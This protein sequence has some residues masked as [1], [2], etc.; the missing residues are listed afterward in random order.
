MTGITFDTSQVGL[1]S[2]LR[3]WQLR[4]LQVLWSCPEGAKSVTVWERVNKVLEGE[5]EP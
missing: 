2:V 4:A 3:T 1:E 5:K